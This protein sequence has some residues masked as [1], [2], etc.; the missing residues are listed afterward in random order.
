MQNDSVHERTTNDS[1]YRAR[2]LSAWDAEYQT[3][4]H[5]ILKYSKLRIYA[6]ADLISF[7]ETLDRCMR[8]LHFTDE[9]CATLLQHSGDIVGAVANCMGSTYN[10]VQGAI[11][12]LL[13]REL[14]RELDR[15]LELEGM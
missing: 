2:L 15:D 7:T 13:D 6:L 8:Q 12:K 14:D 1:F 5:N 3:I 11:D 4:H 9:E 10:V